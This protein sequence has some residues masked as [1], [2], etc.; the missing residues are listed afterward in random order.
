MRELRLLVT[1]MYASL[2]PFP[3]LPGGVLEQRDEEIQDAFLACPSPVCLPSP[4]P[5]PA[6]LQEAFEQSVEEIQDALL[7]RVGAAIDVKVLAA[8]LNAVP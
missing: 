5:S 2:L 8:V 4:S 3:C 1:S 6:Y 7:P